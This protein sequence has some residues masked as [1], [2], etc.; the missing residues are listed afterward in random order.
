V[1]VDPIKPQ[2]KPPGTKCLKVKCDA[3]LSNS[4]FKFNLR[5]YTKEF[6]GDGPDGFPL[7]PAG[8]APPAV[9]A[10]AGLDAALRLVGRCS[11]TLKT[12]LKPP[13]TKPLKP[14]YPVLP[15]NVAL[16]FNLR[17]YSLERIIGLSG[18]HT[19]AVVWAGAYSRSHLRS[20]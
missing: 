10:A 19:G 6:H 4:A 20:T 17:R 12:T 1:Q 15:S 13:G 2:L 3:L 16:K 14:N 9:P 8:R 11:L 5:R 18:E 7:P